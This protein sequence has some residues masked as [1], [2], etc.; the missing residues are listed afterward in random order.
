MKIRGFKASFVVSFLAVL[1]LAGCFGAKMSE[2]DQELFKHATSLVRS[3]DKSNYESAEGVFV[4]LE[5]R[6]PENLELPCWHSQMLLAWGDSLRQELHFI[7]KRH[8]EIQKILNEAQSDLTRVKEW[9]DKAKAQEKVIKMQ[10]QLRSLDKIVEKWTKDSN[11]ALQR[12]ENIVL[13]EI[14]PRDMGHMS[15]RVLADF[16]R[17]K[18]DRQSAEENLV[19]VD[20]NKEDSAGARF[21]RGAIAMDMD[22]DYDKAIA[23][24]DEALSLDPNFVKAKYYK[25]MAQDKK[26]DHEAAK[27]TM[28]DVL[29]DS[30]GHLGAKTYLEITDY[31]TEAMNQ[32]KEFKAQQVLEMDIAP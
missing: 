4:E 24:F 18:G 8:D 12:G 27:A 5:E 9:K 2:P 14:L 10:E 11:D 30:S 28:V 26:G 3:D 17:I 7:N 32:M 25:G 31:I 13:S 29:G 6:Y 1:L 15:W 22:K 21:I 16:Y 20:V 23:Y 19:L